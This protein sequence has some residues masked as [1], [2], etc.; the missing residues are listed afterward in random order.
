MNLAFHGWQLDQ[1]TP[2]N[3]EKRQEKNVQNNK[4][5]MKIS[6]DLVEISLDLVDLCQIQ[7]T[8]FV[9]LGGSDF[10]GGN[11]PLD[12]PLSDFEG[13]DPLSTAAARSIDF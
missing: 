8:L 7:L 5:P 6:L 13:G 3:D 12:P 11:P 10:G 2:T 9:A 4:D 1:S